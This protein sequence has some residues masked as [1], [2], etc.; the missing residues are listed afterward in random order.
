MMDLEQPDL[1]AREGDCIFRIL[2]DD[3]VEDRRRFVENN[4]VNVKNLDV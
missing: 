4:A 3:H 1:D 2:V